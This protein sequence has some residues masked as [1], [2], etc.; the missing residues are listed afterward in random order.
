MKRFFI[1]TFFIGASIV[2]TNCTPQ[3]FG[4]PTNCGW[5][6]CPAGETTGAPGYNQWTKPEK[7]GDNKFMTKG[8]R[9]KDA[10]AGAKS[11]CS[12]LGKT[13]EIINMSDKNVATF[14]CN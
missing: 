11:H 7:I 14:S 2:L 13:M 3:D 12:K 8:N 10:I 5:T 4:S 6:G 1:A 9:Y